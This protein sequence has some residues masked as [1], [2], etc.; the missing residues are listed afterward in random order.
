[1]DCFQPLMEK[2][3]EKEF[4][5]LYSRPVRGNKYGRTEELYQCEDC[6][7]CSHKEILGNLN[8]IR[9]FNLHK[10][11]LKSQTKQLVA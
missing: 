4:T 9:G 11:H 5:Y 7:N 2:F 6:S 10:Y 1:M 3:N 8:C